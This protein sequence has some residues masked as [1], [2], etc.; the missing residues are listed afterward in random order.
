MAHCAGDVRLRRDVPV[1]ETVDQQRIDGGMGLEEPVVGLLQA[2]A[3]GVP[4]DQPQQRAEEP[5]FEPQGH[6]RPVT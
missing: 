5:L 6:L 3:A 4:V 1:L 2:Q